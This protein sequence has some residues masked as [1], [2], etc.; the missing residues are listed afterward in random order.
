MSGVFKSIAKVF[1]KVVKT[2][3]KVLPYVV[4]AAAVVFTAGAAM[5]AA[6][7]A[8]V[9]GWATAI[10][11]QIGAAVGGV[12]GGSSVVAN[13]VASAVTQGIIGSAIGGI[14][15]LATGG[16]IKKGM[17][18]GFAGGAVSGGITGA[19]GRGLI[20]QASQFKLDEAATAGRLGAGQQ[21]SA[22]ITGG[23]GE[24]GGVAAVRRHQ[25]RV[26]PG[27]PERRD[28]P[29][30]A[31]GLGEPV[32]SPVR[33]TGAGVSELRS[34][35]ELGGASQLQVQDKDASALG[36]LLGQV[37]NNKVVN[38]L[39]AGATTAVLAQPDDDRAAAQERANEEARRAE[40]AVEQ[41][42]SGAIAPAQAGA[43]APGLL[44]NT[45]DSTGRWVFVPGVGLEFRRTQ[46]AAAA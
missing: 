15:S 2:V 22:V 30:E 25:A 45:A 39:L 8:G 44:T 40:S 31:G 11:G 36:R 29:V 23:G 21:V 26:S 6:G 9:F 14:T 34:A 12:M 19:L 24:G 7:A 3:K 4:L 1:K 20:P 41:R 38:S 13:I 10:P 43:R 42:Y 17:L 37:S 33:A 16:D 18:V 27:P 32:L 28:V 46:V 35:S 5:G